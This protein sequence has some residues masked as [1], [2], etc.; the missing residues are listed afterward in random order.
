MVIARGEIWWAALP[1]P[2][3]QEKDLKRPVV[4][5]SSDAFNDSAIGTVNAVV[6]T[7]KLELAAAPGNFLLTR[8]QSGLLKDSV[9]NVS[10]L[11]TLDRTYLR[12]RAGG[13]PDDMLD[14]LDRGL[15]LVLDN[16]A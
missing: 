12:D 9:V 6:L 8:A 13:I 15:R 11:V 4:V 14:Q 3:G 5:V 2:S 1:D 16:K 7:S 10:Q